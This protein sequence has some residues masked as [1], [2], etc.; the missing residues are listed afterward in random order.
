[1]PKYNKNVRPYYDDYEES[2]KRG[3]QYT[4]L[5]AHPGRVAQAREFT[6]M[7][8]VIKDIVKSIGDSFMKDGDIVEGCQVTI[9]NYSKDQLRVIVDTGKVYMNGMVLSVSSQSLDLPAIGRFDVG[10]VLDEEVVTEIND[11]TLLDPAEGFDNH[12]YPGCDRINSTI[13]L[14]KIDE[15]T[16]EAALLVTIENGSVLVENSGPEYNVLNQTLARRT[17]D[18][19]GS[20]IVNG[21]NVSLMPTMLGEEEDSSK[22]YVVVESGKAYVQGYELKIPAPRNII[23]N[24]SNTT[25]GVIASKTYVA[26]NIPEDDNDKKTITALDER[27]FANI[28]SVT[29]QGARESGVI[30]LVNSNLTVSIGNGTEKVV[31]GSVEVFSVKTKTPVDG[32]YWTVGVQSNQ[33]NLTS[34]TWDGSKIS[35]LGENFQYYIK[36]RVEEAYS[37]DVEVVERDSYYYLRWI[38]SRRPVDNTPLTITYN[39]YLARKDLVCLDMLGNVKIVEGVP[40]DYGFERLP[41]VPLDH[42]TLAHIYNPPGGSVISK[43]SNRK[44][45]VSNVALTRFTMQD[46]QE[47]LDRVRKIEYDQSILSLNEEARKQGSTNSMTGIFTDPLL[48]LSKIDLVYQLEKDSSKSLHDVTID[49]MNNIC[50]LPVRAETYDM[51]DKVLP[52]ST[53]SQHDKLITLKRTGNSKKVLSQSSATTSFAVNPYSKFPATPEINITPFMDSWIDDSI[54]EV[55]KTQ[56]SSEIVSSSTRNVEAYNYQGA[57]RADTITRNSVETAIGTRVETTSTESIIESKASK[58]IRSRTI[59]IEGRDFNK[60]AGSVRCTFDGIPVKLTPVY[61]EQAESPDGTVQVDN[62]GK[63]TATFTIPKSTFMTG[64]REVRVESTNPGSVDNYTGSAFALYQ[65]VGTDRTIQRTVTTLTTVLLNRVTTVTTT[66]NVDPLGQTFILNRLSM[67]SGIDIYFSQVASDTTPV[68]CEIREVV[69]GNITS[70]VLGHKTL[71]SL[72]ITENNKRALRA[73]TDATQATRFRFDD[74]VLLSANTEYAFVISSTSTDYSLWVSELGKNDIQSN[75]TVLTNPYLVG[76]MMSSSNNSSWTIHQTTD[77]K[78]DLIEDEYENSS[79]LEFNTIDTTLGGSIEEFSRVYLLAET[80]KPEG[81]SIKWEYEIT[82]DNLSST[83]EDITPYSL[84]TK[85]I[86]NKIKLKAILT[87]EADSNLSPII[88]LDSVS[89]GLSTYDTTANKYP[90]SNV[91]SV[92]EEDGYYYVSEMIS[93]LDNFNKVDI[94]LDTYNPADTTIDVYVAKT[95]NRNLTTSTVRLSG[96]DTNKSMDYNWVERKYTISGNEFSIENEEDDTVSCRIF[97]KLKSKS[98]AVT[99]AFKKLRAIFYTE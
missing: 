58:Y 1:M 76:V 95:N 59:T 32:K 75:K 27:Y 79:V 46:I 63:F 71:S 86:G 13:K 40:A 72:D 5:L 8:S 96:T 48:D 89:L 98:H 90:D 85:K 21:L 19:S 47:L 6:Q 15:A 57:R 88:V 38:N 23:A 73:S 60:V 61:P 45:Y 2:K 16:V 99:P 12:S 4:H 97:V 83:I 43:S 28:V 92:D 31:L 68:T 44:I 56:N 74:P 82:K 49:F 34:L 26:S 3:K 93:N 91:S 17:N 53:A 7:Q 42:L 37:N 33:S 50:Y 64:I 18:E 10:F 35:E 69:N 65:A 78:F 77:I 9:D 84:V 81:T 51:Y 87:K 25:K 14:V 66:H 20:Y 29:G 80:I 62:T 54:I 94:Y 11:P 36:Y 70:T 67:I 41:E 52:A 22:Y 55:L 30:S 39:Y 24:R